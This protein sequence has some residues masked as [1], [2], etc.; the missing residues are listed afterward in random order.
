MSEWKSIETAPTDGTHIL[1]VDA[2]DTPFAD[3]EV[4]MGWWNLDGWRDYGVRGCNG[5]CDYAPTHWMPLPTP[6][7]HPSLFTITQRD[8]E[9]LRALLTR[10]LAGGDATLAEDSRT[11]LLGRTQ[12]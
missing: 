7:N 6:P 3:R 10:W 9:R 1:L 5:Q 11:A 2:E 8:N 12:G 4:C